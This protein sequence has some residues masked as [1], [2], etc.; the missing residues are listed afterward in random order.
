MKAD[1]YQQG[2]QKLAEVDGKQGQRVIEALTPIAPDFATMLIEMFGDIY[3]RPQ[4]DLKAREIATVAALTALG[5]AT[6]QLKVH[7]NGAL[8]V[9]CSAQ[10]IVE[11]MMQMALY[12]GFPA[13][14]NGLFAAQDV[15]Q[16]R[17]ID[18]TQPTKAS[19]QFTQGYFVTAELKITD[20]LRIEEAKHALN[21]LCEQTRQESGCSLFELH[22]CPSEPSKLLLWERFDSKEAFEV[23]HNAPHTLAYKA[24]GLTEVVSIC[25][26][27][28]YG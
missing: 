22:E 28:L 10:E 16:E 26:S 14:L 8:N 17:A 2:W 21:R 9:G 18:V 6:P 3:G 20:V 19:S 4:L 12:A 27:Q 11:V 15:F 7:L 24:K 5:N 1:R 23:H 25:Q 13:A